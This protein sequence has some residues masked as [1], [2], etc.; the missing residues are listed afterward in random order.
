MPPVAESVNA[1]VCHMTLEDATAT[2]LLT[3]EQVLEDRRELRAPA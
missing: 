2:T 3:A 1:F